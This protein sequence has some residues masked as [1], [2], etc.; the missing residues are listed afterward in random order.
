MRGVSDLA[1]R[2]SWPRASVA[3]IRRD[4]GCFV[5]AYA[6]PYAGASTLSDD[7]L[8]SPLAELG[9]IRATGRR[10]GFRFVRGPK[11]TLDPAVVCYAISNFWNDYAPDAN[12]LSFEALAHA[13]GSPGRVFV[14]GEDDLVL[15][16]ASMGD[17]TRG[18]YR[19]SEDG[20]PQATH[21][22]A[23]ACG[24]RSTRPR[25]H[26]LPG[27]DNVSPLSEHVRVARRF[28]RSV[29]LETDLSDAAALE[30]FKC[31]ASS[32]A[33]L[34][35][36]AGACIRHG[37]R[38]LHLDGAVRGWQVEPGR[39]ARSSARRADSWGACV[40]C[41]RRRG[42][43]HAAHSAA[44]RPPRLAR[45]GGHGPPRGPVRRDR[46]SA[47]ARPARTSSSGERLD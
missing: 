7:A 28:R 6:T 19:W 42:R 47:A 34:T 16:L 11:P 24:G 3:T 14:L 46:R 40:R 5:R 10:D 17:L 41:A 31:P 36:M 20:G 37:S 29:R 12:T 26:R 23:S 9:L 32:E 33:V 39:G 4:V 15:M 2:C 1:A 18:V 44:A 43:E 35:A 25:A 27:G 8:E 21:S 38:R 13:G 45:A 30:G 22:R